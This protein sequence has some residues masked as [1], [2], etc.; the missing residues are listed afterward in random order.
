MQRQILHNFHV[1]A[2]QRR[3][4]SSRKVKFPYSIINT[5]GKVGVQSLADVVGIGQRFGK[6]S[7]NTDTKQRKSRPGR[8]T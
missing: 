6:V 5:R 8:A 2:E 7:M 3:P 4:T 1:D